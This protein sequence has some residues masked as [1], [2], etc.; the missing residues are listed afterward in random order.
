VLFSLRPEH[1]R[2]PGADT[3]TNS[4]SNGQVRVRGRVLHQA[5]HGA[6]EL[7]RVECT[8]GLVLVV[9]IASASGVQDK[10]KDE[11]DLEFSAADAVPVRDSPERN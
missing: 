1:I 9:R 7:L 10:N 11:V 5:F 4:R 6:T 8:D 2:L 3:S